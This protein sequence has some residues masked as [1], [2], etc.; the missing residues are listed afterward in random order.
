MLFAS[1]FDDIIGQGIC[2]LIKRRGVTQVNAFRKTVMC[3]PVESVESWRRCQLDQQE[4]PD[5]ICNGEEDEL[6]FGLGEPYIPATNIS[7]MSVFRH[8]QIFFQ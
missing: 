8:V 7:G 3:I 2:F 6:L 4:V 5:L 1:R